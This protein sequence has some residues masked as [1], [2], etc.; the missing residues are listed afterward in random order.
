MW[1]DLGKEDYN[2]GYKVSSIME[3]Q[4]K[5]AKRRK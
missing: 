1:L 5:K 3:F 2:Y 4:W